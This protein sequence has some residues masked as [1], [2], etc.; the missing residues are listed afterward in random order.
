[1]LDDEGVTIHREDTKDAKETDEWDRDLD[2][3]RAEIAE[4]ILARV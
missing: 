4:R 1:M 3:V 2:V